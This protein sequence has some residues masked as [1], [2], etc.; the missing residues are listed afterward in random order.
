MRRA[1]T[2]SRG[3]RPTRCR[4][5]SSPPP[6]RRR[7]GGSCASF[8]DGS[9]L[10]GEL[11]AVEDGA[12]RVDVPGVEGT[13]RVPVA[14]LRSLA[15]PRQ[16]PPPEEKPASTPRLE[17]E[18]VRLLGMLVEGIEDGDSSCLAWKPAGGTAAVPLRHGFAG[19]VVFKDPPPPPPKQT[20]QA[21]RQA[22]RVVVQR[23]AQPAGLGVR[24]INALAGN[25]QPPPP[26]SAAST[27]PLAIHLR[28]GDVIPSEVAR[29]DEQGVTFKSPHSTSTFIP[30]EKIKAVELARD[31]PPA[32]R[33]NRSKRERL[34]TLP[35]MQKGS[36]PTHLIALA[37]RRLPP[38]AGRGDGRPEAS[39][40][41]PPRDEGGPARP[42]RADHL[43]PRR[44]ARRD[45]G[46][47]EGP[48]T[49]RCDARPGA[50]PRWNPAHL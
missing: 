15:A 1:R 21:T 4:A 46:P 13:V 10:S 47:R 24:I 32:L 40:R 5:S 30:H 43:V 20:L 34:L 42:G 19:R 27:A 7:R 38:R 36:P 37:E 6:P 25:G 50:P 11:K 29:I 12:L 44:R 2:P 48:R 14:G 31:E 18:G 28:T 26:A 17:G 3:S 41:G 33:L 16:A 9:R 39:G 22:A 49:G 45:Q 8:A 35:R 23:Q